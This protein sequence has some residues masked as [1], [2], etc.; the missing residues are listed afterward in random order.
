M[1]R[2][3][4]PSGAHKRKASKQK[5]EKEDA[6][7]AKTPRISDFFN[8][9]AKSENDPVD[10]TS[11]RRPNESST[12]ESETMV[13]AAVDDSAEDADDLE[14]GPST[15]DQKRMTS[16]PA[17]WF[18]ITEIRVSSLAK[19]AVDQNKKE[20]DAYPESKRSYPPAEGGVGGTNRFFKNS[21]F[22]TR[23]D[24]GEQRLRKWLIYSSLKGMSLSLKFISS[25]W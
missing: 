10:S 9:E 18:P 19:L 16:D 5:A 8:S 4:Q 20:S 24:N 23:H 21:M 12:H 6:V 11:S 17:T 25:I 14:A 2:T 3:V 22:Y 13:V 1:P 7:L 15:S